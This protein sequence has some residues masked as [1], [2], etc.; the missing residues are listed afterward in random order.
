VKKAAVVILALAL[1]M[2]SS[3]FASAFADATTKIEHANAGG[4]G[5]IDVPGH[6]NV[7][8]QASHDNWGDYFSGS[9]DRIMV[10]VSGGASGIGVPFKYVA[11]YEDNPERI[12]FSFE[13]GGGAIQLKRYQLE[14][15][16][17]GKTVF[18]CWTVPLEIPATGPNVFGNYPT[19]AVTIPPGCLVLQGYGDVKSAT[20]S[21]S[22][23]T[24]S[25][26]SVSQYYDAKASFI[27]PRWHYCG[28][29]GTWFP[30]TR[31]LKDVTV[32]WTHV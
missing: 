13:V 19:P 15:F 21:Q 29:V 16:R 22:Y 23:P 3:S 27:C 4:N 20:L 30:L 9:A 1:L 5:V 6:T 31:A 32:T 24:W 12:A 10:F 28:P 18:V 2:M 8:I 26:V 17:I 7:L 25:Y 14:I 11:A